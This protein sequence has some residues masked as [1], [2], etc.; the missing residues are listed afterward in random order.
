[1]HLPFCTHHF[2]WFYMM[3]IIYTKIAR[4]SGLT[5]YNNL[6]PRSW[7]T[8]WFDLT[9][10]FTSIDIHYVNWIIMWCNLFWSCK[11]MYMCKYVIFSD[12]ALENYIL[13]CSRHEDVYS[14]FVNSKLFGTFCEQ[15]KKCIDLI[16]MKITVSRT[17]EYVGTWRK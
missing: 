1:M 7:C 17:S 11:Y 6:R 5:I 15:I 9:R 10:L 12:L 13:L 8:S 16:G 14:I 2:L 4:G 3:N